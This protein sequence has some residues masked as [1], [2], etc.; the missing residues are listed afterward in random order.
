MAKFKIEDLQKEYD[1]AGWKLLSEEYVNLS[2]QMECICP[3]GHTNYLTY[4]KWRKHHECPICSRSALVETPITE[5][6]PKP[7]NSERILS[8]DQATNVSGWAVFDNKKLVKYGVFSS[9]HASSLEKINDVKNW[10]LNMIISWRPDRVIIEDIQYQRN[11]DGGAD[12]VVGVTTFKVLAQ[13]QGVIENLF[14]TNKVIF[15]VAHTS[16]WREYNSIKGK[17]RADKKKSAQFIVK[18]LYGIN[19]S[20]DEA[21]AICIGR[22]GLSL[23]KEVSFSEW[24]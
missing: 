10:L 8:I 17:T 1:E 23:R 2:N 24:I 7:L 9:P 20:Q 16:V 6:I 15:D 5:V 21:D 14:F 3:E 13:L 12:G 19:V 22:Y 4:E 18:E 11:Y